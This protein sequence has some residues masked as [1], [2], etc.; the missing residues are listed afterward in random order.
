MR[1]HIFSRAS[2][3]EAQLSANRNRS[4]LLDKAGII[5]AGS[6]LLFPDTLTDFV[7]A[8]GHDETHAEEV[9]CGAEATRREVALKQL[10]AQRLWRNDSGLA[11]GIAS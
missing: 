7:E 1:D 4:R 6:I 3:L 10:L 11:G 9:V 5:K 8:V 2:S